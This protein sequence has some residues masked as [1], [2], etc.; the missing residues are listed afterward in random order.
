[1]VTD[2]CYTTFVQEGLKQQD[3]C[4]GSVQCASP[5]LEREEVLWMALQFADDSQSLIMMK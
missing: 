1:M 2:N 5:S 3:S 4:L